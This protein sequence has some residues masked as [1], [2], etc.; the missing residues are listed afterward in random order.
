MRGWWEKGEKEVEGLGVWGERRKVDIGR[1][2]TRGW[3][4]EGEVEGEQT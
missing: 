2:E 1:K 4:E 3:G